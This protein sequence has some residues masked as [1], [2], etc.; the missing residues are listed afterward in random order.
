[1]APLRGAANKG[2]RPSK[3]ARRPRTLRIPAELDQVIESNSDAA[4]FESVNDYIC[5]MLTRALEAGFSPKPQDRLP[6]SA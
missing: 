6:L 3:G 2:G 1:M 5:L 4:G